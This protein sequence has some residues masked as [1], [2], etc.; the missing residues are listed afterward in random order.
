MYCEK[1][2]V[3]EAA[4]RKLEGYKPMG[5]HE[6]LETKADEL[7]ELAKNVFEDNYKEH[8]TNMLAIAPYNNIYSALK[9]SSEI[10]HAGN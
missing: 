2:G 3:G 8:L 4:F 1:H 9:N 10:L 6:H 7:I 5:I